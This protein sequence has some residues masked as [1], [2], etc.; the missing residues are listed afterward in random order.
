ML[1]WVKNIIKYILKKGKTEYILLVAV[2]DNLQ[3]CGILLYVF[4]IAPYLKLRLL[5]FLVPTLIRK[6]ET[7]LK[8]TLQKVA[9]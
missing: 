8:A 7:N 5:S 2:T 6:D 3:L 9:T 1:E 4:C